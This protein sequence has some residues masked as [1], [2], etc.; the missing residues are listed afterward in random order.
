MKYTLV[1]LSVLLIATTVSAQSSWTVRDNQTGKTVTITE[2]ITRSFTV[3][4]Q[5]S[6]YYGVH[7]YI[8]VTGTG[9]SWPV[10]LIR[11]DTRETVERFV[12]LSGLCNVYIRDNISYH[13]ED[14]VGHTLKFSLEP[15]RLTQKRY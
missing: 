15:P 9:W 10:L 5:G 7:Y 13:F 8:E 12:Q 2:D 14:T 1:F 3:S 6:D 11:D 4:R